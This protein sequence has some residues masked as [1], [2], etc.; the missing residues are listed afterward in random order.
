MIKGNK[1]EWSELYALLKL[2]YLGRLYTAD[3]NAQRIDN[4]YFP[5]LKIFRDEGQL[6]HIEYILTTPSGDIDV[7]LESVKRKSLTKEW[8]SQASS[9]IFCGILEGTNRAFEI[10]E[11]NEIMNQLGLNRIAAPSS[12]KTDIKMQIHDIHTGYNPICGFSVKSELGSSPTLLNASGAT[13]FV[14]EVFGISDNDMDNINHI[15]S[16]TKILDRINAILSQGSMKFKKANNDIFSGN[17]ML[18]DSYMEDIIAE[19][20]LKYYQNKAI[21]CKSLINLIEKENP[22]GYPREGFYIFKFKKFLCS[23]ALGMMPSKAWDGIDEA[24]GGYVIVKED[25]DVLAYHLYNRNAFETYLLNN[26]KFEKG[27]TT[28]HG[29]ATL[30]KGEDDKKY[31]NLNLQIR[32][33]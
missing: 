14:F 7:Y 16:N 15:E 2:L 10:V 23:V 26:T 29:F 25:G 31:I 27:S 1:G 12:D 21:N 13:N 9:Q 28:R 32:F 17:L 22:L 5:V 4:K 3:E 19:M 8:I 20:L 33:I 24:N 11:A 30:Y 18:I 6:G